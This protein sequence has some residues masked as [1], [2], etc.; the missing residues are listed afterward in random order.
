MCYN[1][2]VFEEF[3][4]GTSYNIVAFVS[5]SFQ[6][7]QAPSLYDSFLCRKHAP[8]SPSRASLKRLKGMDRIFF[9][10]DEAKK[11]RGSG[12]HWDSDPAGQAE[13]CRSKQ[14]RTRFDVACR[15]RSTPHLCYC[16]TSN[17][18]HRIRTY[19]APSFDVS[20]AACI[21]V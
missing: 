20:T 19:V 4:G 9:A 10:D 8:P 12:R 13:Q 11:R 6:T 5:S 21:V 7:P 15:L 1:A 2:R 3:V 16:A 18:T 14:C 17:K